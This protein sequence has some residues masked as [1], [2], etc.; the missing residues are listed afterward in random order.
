MIADRPK[1]E[2]KM[3]LIND[4]FVCKSEKLNPGVD[5]YRLKTKHLVKLN[6]EQKA[7]ECDATKLNQGTEAGPKIL[8]TTFPV[9]IS[10]TYLCRP[11]AKRA[12][13]LNNFIIT[14]TRK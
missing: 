8:L 2:I 9:L 1:A 12:A 7:E 11:V 4:E 13:G 5:N 14:N 6:S 3:I 10:N